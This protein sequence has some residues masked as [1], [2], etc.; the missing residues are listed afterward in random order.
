M[1]RYRK[2]QAELRAKYAIDGKFP[3]QCKFCGELFYAYRPD[4]QTC[5]QRCRKAFSRSPAGHM[6][7]LKRLGQSGDP[8][9]TDRR[10]GALK[11]RGKAWRREALWTPEPLEA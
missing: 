1:T 6:A 2:M 5:S 4:A 10:L 3:R 9:E 11:C 7:R 8:Y